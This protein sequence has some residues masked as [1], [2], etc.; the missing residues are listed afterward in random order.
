M[1]NYQTPRTLAECEFTSGY[2][3]KW[4]YRPTPQRT[5]RIRLEWVL[6]VS[7]TITAVI[8]SYAQWG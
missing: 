3:E 8:A 4:L 5:M 7:A 2:P 6:Y 1:K